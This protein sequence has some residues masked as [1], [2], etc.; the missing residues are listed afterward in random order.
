MEMIEND[1]YGL[2]RRHA[3]VY[4][5][6]STF[7]QQTDRQEVE[8]VDFARKL[9][10]LFDPATDIYTDVVSG[11]REG[12]DRPMFSCLRQKI[13]KGEYGLIL[14]SEMSRLD[15]KPSNF[16]RAIEYFQER[17]VWL[18]FH[19]Q[20]MWVKDK[21]DLSTQIMLSVLSIMSQYEIE[22][23]A[24]RGLDGKISAIRTRGSYCG[25]PAPYGYHTDFKEHRLEPDCDE[26]ANVRWIFGTYAEGES[27]GR[28]TETLNAR[29]VPSP[30]RIRMQQAMERREAKGMPPKS[31]KRFSAP[32]SMLWNT[33]TVRHILG[34][35][36]YVGKMNYVFHEP[37]PSN[38]VPKRRRDGR[39]V[40]QA[41]MM[42]NDAL[43]LVDDGLFEKVAERLQGGTRI[44]PIAARRPTL[45]ASVIKCGHCGRAFHVSHNHC[46]RSYRC[47]GKM[48]ADMPGRCPSGACIMVD[49]MDGLVVAASMDILLL[50]RLIN[51]SRSEAEAVRWLS[52]HYRR[53]VKDGTSDV[54]EGDLRKELIGDRALLEEA[55]RHSISGISI[56][57]LC[58]P[59]MLVD[60]T[61]FCGSRRWATL[62]TG[63]YKASEMTDKGEMKS[64]CINNDSGC[65]NYNSEACLI[66][67]RH[68]DRT[69]NYSPQE[70]DEI[71]RK[72]GWVTA[73]RPLP[74]R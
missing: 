2:S 35:P 28:I 52:D 13:E 39:R 53:L 12:Q 44:R 47:S 42:E 30:Y 43:R 23:F 32:E 69:V 66:E 36:L 14:F 67:Y 3:A 71:V 16:L 59:W 24:T 70:F 19:K 46:G 29:G 10:L 54:W 55:V 65:Y 18:Y 4:V 72:N 40:Y 60:I 45:L 11:F 8:L 74:D 64:W 26:A 1:E 57:R 61:Y 50:L 37:D 49:K 48:L 15:R 21:T 38:P 58:G 17:G 22:L 41:V 51:S 25:G 62:K 63:R 33:S 6:V 34:N 73:F 56:H 20:D 7:Q 5:R 31:Y 27:I 68:G 9:N